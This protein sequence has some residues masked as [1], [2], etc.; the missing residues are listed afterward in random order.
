MSIVKSFRTGVGDTYYI[1]HN[2][3]NFTIIDCRIDEHRDDILE[4]IENEA[5]VKG[6]VRFISTH[7]DDDH[8]RGLVRLDDALGLRN[9][10]VVENQATK[11]DFTEDFERYCELRDSDKA[12]YLERGCS[13]RWMNRSGEERETSGVNILWPATSDERFQTALSS[14][15]NGGSPNNLSII[16]KYSRAGGATMLWFGDLETDFMKSIED[17]IELPPAD[18]IFAAHHGR[19]QMPASWMEQMDPK[20]VVLGEAPP[21]YLEYYTGRDHLRQ[22]A[23]G[24]I[25]LSA[26]GA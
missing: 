15:N 3:D 16:L 5:A 22:N 12:F 20:V 24:D 9:F 18:I 7:P 6:I 8:L 4:E 13:R 23:T 21:E 26:S 19:A 25:I 1:A 17:E 14:A 2:S 10:Y 11:P